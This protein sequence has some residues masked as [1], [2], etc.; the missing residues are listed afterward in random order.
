[1]DLP[2]EDMHLLIYDNTHDPLILETIIECINDF[3]CPKC[4]QFRSIRIY[5]SFLKPRGALTGSANEVFSRSQLANIWSMW[6]RIYN[7]I[8]TETFFQLEDDTI[9]PSDAF[10][11]LYGLLMSNSKHGFITAIETGR[12][13]IP[14]IATRLGIHKIVMRKGV[15][16][17]RISLDPNLTGIQKIDSAGVFCF[18][19]RTKAYKSGFENYNPIAKAFSQFAMDNVLTYNIKKH[20][21]KL[22]ADFDCWCGHMQLIPSGICIFGKDQALPFSDL[23]IPEYHSYA[24]GVERKKLGQKPR[25]YKVKSPAAV[26][27]LVPDENIGAADEIKKI[28]QKIREEKKRQK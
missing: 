15:L 16:L 13:S 21:W 27:S 9:C 18:A 14:Y 3:L 20:G 5:K 7:M 23:Y 24:I 17:K 12:N 11:R 8:H 26:I 1:M 4:R 10:T 2:R 6:K 28:K 22:F 25:S 19:A